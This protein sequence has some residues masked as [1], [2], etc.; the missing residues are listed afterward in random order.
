MGGSG[1]DWWI[2]VQFEGFGIIADGRGQRII[3][4]HRLVTRVTWLFDDDDHAGTDHRDAG[5]HHDNFQQGF[6]V[7]PRSWGL[8][9]V[10]GKLRRL[11]VQLECRPK[12]A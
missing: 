10:R 5:S 8:L 12:L 11:G 6:H 2:G 7:C 9:I 4:R 1:P 3:T